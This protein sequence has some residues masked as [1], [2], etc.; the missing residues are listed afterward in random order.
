MPLFG[1]K[2][3]EKITERPKTAPPQNETSYFG[4]N[5]MIKGRVSGNGNVIILGALDGEFN[6]RG[7]VKVAQPAKI[8]GEVK[9]DVISVN[10]SVQG[11][12]A[13][14]ERI[15]FQ[16]LP[17]SIG[18]VGLGQRHRLGLAFNA[19]VRSGEIG[20]VM[21]G[22][23]HHDTGGTDSPFRETANIKDGSNIMA[24]MAT[25]CFAGN[26]ARGMTLVALHN[27]GG[28][29]WGEV[30]N[31]GFGMVIDGSQ[32]AEER[33]KMMLH[34][35]VNNGIARRSW[36]QNKPAKFAIQH[37]MKENPDLKVTLP[38]EADENLLNGLL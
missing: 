36:A 37:A 12:L 21:L 19:M 3:N 2:K 9:A 24:D 14:R 33:L 38:N 18:W 10:G 26:A 30:I 20:P 7:R 31:G 35:D 23:D 34:W 5:L 17:A 28:V 25:Q 11:S 8:K 6:L 4:K 29:G 32:E 22:R 1:K 27:G 15:H 16:G 13:A